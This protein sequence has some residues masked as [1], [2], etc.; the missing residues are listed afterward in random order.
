MIN[1]NDMGITLF[2]VNSTF[3]SFE[4]VT[5]SPLTGNIEKTPCN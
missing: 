1:S 3:T 4:S 2:E 5:C